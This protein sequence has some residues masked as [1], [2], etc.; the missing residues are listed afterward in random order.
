MKKGFFLLLLLLLQPIGPEWANAQK[1]RIVLTGS[2]TIAPLSAEIGRLFEK[3]HPGVLV[4]VQTG[5]SFRGVADVRRGLSDIGMV[6]R[7]LKKDETDLYAFPIALDGVTLIVHK[8]NPVHTL[9]NAEIVDI[10]RGRI[11]NWKTL[12]GHDAPMTV[13]NKSEGHSTLALFTDYFKIKNQDIR[14]DVVIGDNAQ[15]I[16]TVA[17]NPDAVG[18][19]SIGAAEYSVAQGIPIKLLAVAG[20]LPS[21]ENV[22]KGLFPI[23]R[24]LNLVTLT[25]PSGWILTFIQF[26]R[27]AEAQLIVEEQYFVPIA[28]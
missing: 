18:Y 1:I 9:S 7:A 28:N 27:S 16:K 22:Q 13:V 11:R 4:D 5:G 6:S 25:E 21:T 8:N 19:V 10:Y 12:G 3:Q 14:A 15:G 23:L 26:A 20:I 2:S 24:P 17:S